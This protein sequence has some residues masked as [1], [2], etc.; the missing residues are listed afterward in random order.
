MRR[1]IANLIASG[2]ALLVLLGM[3]TAVVV[4]SKEEEH[5]WLYEAVGCIFTVPMALAMWSGKMRKP[6]DE[7]VAGPENWKDWL[8][9]SLVGF[10]ISA[11]FLAFDVFVAQGHPGISAV[12][13]VGAV[14]ITVVSLP[15][16]IRAWLLD[17]L[18]DHAGASDA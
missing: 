3:V 8:L 17:L 6:S 10:A 11:L 7:P 18:Q 2:T 4:L 15:S 13:T 1:P 14:V 5:F 9:L 16:A 12:F